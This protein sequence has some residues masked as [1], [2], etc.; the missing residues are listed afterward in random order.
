MVGQ[1]LGQQAIEDA[2]RAW[3]DAAQLETQAAT[4]QKFSFGQPYCFE[5]F[6][7][8]KRAK[9]AAKA[10]DWVYGGLG[11]FE[12]LDRRLCEAKC[13]RVAGS[14]A[15][16]C[17]KHGSKAAKCLRSAP[18]AAARVVQALTAPWDFPAEELEEVRRTNRETTEAK[19]LEAK[20]AAIH[21]PEAKKAAIHTP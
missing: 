16:F 3:C 12:W 5:E 6:C 8:V 19:R 4:G 15:K 21:T 17:S 9:A 18:E 1:A 2:W 7:P 20:K 14:W 10:A 11:L 13:M